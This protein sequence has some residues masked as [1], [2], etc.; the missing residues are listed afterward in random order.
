MFEASD[1]NERSAFGKNLLDTISAQLTA[2]FGKGFDVS[3]LRNMRRFYVA[4]PIQNALR[5]ELNWMQ[6]RLIMK[7]SNAD[8]QAFYE[9]ECAKSPFGV[10]KELHTRKKLQA[11]FSVCSFSHL[12]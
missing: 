10:M 4:F 9:E 12:S 8:A 6:Y 5:S 7:I 2:E 11:E 3:N 1:E